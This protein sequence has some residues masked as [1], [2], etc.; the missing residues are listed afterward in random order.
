M[1][2]LPS[3]L[4]NSEQITAEEFLM[5]DIP[6]DKPSCGD[7]L[8]NHAPILIPTPISTPVHQR[9]VPSITSPPTSSAHIHSSPESCNHEPPPSVFSPHPLLQRSDSEIQ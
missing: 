3:T 2:K 1:L 8:L 7:N 6:I 5:L 9:E 4:P